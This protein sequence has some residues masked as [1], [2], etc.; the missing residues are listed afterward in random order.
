MRPTYVFAQLNKYTVPC[1]IAPDVSTVPNKKE[2][3]GFRRLLYDR[4][5][6]FMA[7]E[8]V[9]L[10]DALIGSDALVAKARIN[11]NPDMLSEVIAQHVMSAEAPTSKAFGS[12]DDLFRPLLCYAGDAAYGDAALR[13]S[14]CL[15]AV[16]T[17]AH[18]QA[19]LPCMCEG[20]EEHD[21][22]AIINVIKTQH[23]PDWKGYLAYMESQRANGRIAAKSATDL[24]L[25]LQRALKALN[26]GCLK[27]VEDQLCLFGF[28]Y[29]EIGMLDRT[30][31][32][33]SRFRLTASF[34]IS[35]C[36]HDSRCFYLLCPVQLSLSPIPLLAV[37]SQP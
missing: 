29:H 22:Q 9:R 36:T 12:A 14:G 15:P 33:H 21:Q 28:P 13:W 2:P 26:D 7:M 11:P 18:R 19:L 34:S 3:L 32:L 20:I 31:L 27:A 30:L 16:A 6:A 25:R 5:R 4:Q 24:R 37:D 8:I 1:V 35:S 10:R 23:Q 17:F